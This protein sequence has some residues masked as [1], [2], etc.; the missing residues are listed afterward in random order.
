MGLFDFFKK[1][2]QSETISQPKEENISN[3]EIVKNEDNSNS[4]SQFDK[5]Y[6]ARN[7]LYD[8]DHNNKN[9]NSGITEGGYYD[10]TML[11]N[12]ERNYILEKLNE[13][14]NKYSGDYSAIGLCFVS[15]ST[16]YKP[17]YIM[18]QIV[19][20]KY[21]NSEKPLDLLAVAIAY[22]KKG[23][24]YRKKAIEYFEKYYENPI[25]AAL[26]N[27]EYPLFDE[28]YLALNLSDLY[29]K[30]YEFEKAVSV[31]NGYLQNVNSKDMVFIEKIGQ[32]LVK[33]DINKAVSYLES[34]IAE[35][36][37]QHSIKST[38][39]SALE[40]QQKGYVYKP[41]KSK[42]KEEDIIIDEQIDALAKQF[43]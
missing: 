5:R 18:P 2:K 29:E 13:A 21:G 39:N 35:Y 30:E 33:I 38:Y 34:M 12:D 43:L 27:S 4:A 42:P 14:E 8:I 24:R 15:I 7:S 28:R 17:G 32:I 16:V 41:R 31:L 11:T 9:F 19:I 3:V 22:S 40:K 20:L 10:F 37:E 36:P 26:P 6:G 23:A 25:P 1:K